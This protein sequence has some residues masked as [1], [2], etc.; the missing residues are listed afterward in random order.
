MIG[1]LTGWGN[2]D[3]LVGR[4]RNRFTLRLGVLQDSKGHLKV[5][6]LLC[7]NATLYITNLTQLN[8]IYLK[9]KV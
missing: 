5:E 8:Y 6:I 2:S 4:G 7:Y 9:T 1:S 3:H